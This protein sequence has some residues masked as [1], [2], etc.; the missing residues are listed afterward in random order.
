MG[1]SRHVHAGIIAVCLLA[2]S[3][4]PAA[5]QS[6]EVFVPAYFDPVQQNDSFG[7][8]WDDLMKAADMLKAAG[9]ITV[10][11]NPNSGPGG[12]KSQD[13]VN[14][15][16]R[17]RNKGGRVL[18][19]V[20]TCYGG[21]DDEDAVPECNQMMR[22]P[23]QVKADIETDIGKYIGWYHIDGFFLDEMTNDS[24]PAHLK[25]YKDIYNY[26]KSKN[27]RYRVIGNPGANTIK[28]YFTQFLTDALVIFEGPDDPKDADDPNNADE[29][30]KTF[31][32]YGWVNKYCS[33]RF[34][35]IVFKTPPDDP[36]PLLN[37]AASRN[38]GFVFM[39][40]ENDSYTSLPSYWNKEVMEI[41]K[42][43]ALNP[44]PLCTS[45][46]PLAW[47]GNAY[48][49]LGDGTTT[50]RLVPVPVS[51]LNGASA[52]A[53]GEEHS[54][55]L[56]ADGTVLAW[57]LNSYGEL[58]NG[59]TTVSLTPVPVTNLSGVIAIAAG[60]EHSLAL[61]AD[62]TVSAWGLNR[63]G[64]LG[65]GTAAVS[66]TPVPV[67][68]LVGVIAIAAGQEHS[69]ALKADG[70]VLAWGLNFYGELGNG[71][72]T[73]GFT[74]APVSN[75]T[76]V[77]AIAAGGEHS[78]ALKADGTVLAWG[79]NAYG[80]LGNGT[81]TVSLTPVPVSNLGGVIAIAA[82]HEH[83]L[84]LKADGTVRA[85]GLNAYGELGDATTIVS[86]TATPVSNL[87]EV[88]AIAAGGE[89]SLALAAF[90]TPAGNNVVVGPVDATT[91]TRPATLIFS[92]VNQAGVTTLTSSSMGPKVPSGFQLG[93]PSVYYQ[94]TTTA[95]F[96]PPVKVCISYSGITFPNNTPRLFHYENGMG[97]DVTT[98]VDSVNQMICGTV[99]SLSPF[100]LFVS[101]DTTP[102][103]TTAAA[104]PASGADG[105]NNSN[106]TVTLTSTDNEPGATGVKEIH[107]SLTGAQAGNTVVSGSTAS[108]TIS[109]EGSAVIT[110]FA[111]DNAGNKETPGTLTMRIDKTPPA[112]VCGVSPAVLWPPDHALVP[113]T[114]LV[115]VTDTL[116]G[117]AGFTLLSVTSNERDEGLGDGDRSHDIQG[118]V[119]GTPSTRSRLRAER[120]GP[121]SGRLYTLVYQ[122]VD[123]AGN[124]AT[125][126]AAV[127]VPH[128]RS[129]PP[130]SR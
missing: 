58:G 6:L 95:V 76:G 118:F 4:L 91:G 63:S 37:L 112:V 52:I 38:A 119:I 60:G 16:D 5:A 99:N 116:S 17:F 80:E 45:L 57:G 130:A 94:L 128:D 108:V 50:V 43:A 3:G 78:L 46:P 11:I 10:I 21:A 34:A 87:S 113:V 97:S 129:A 62:G 111:L 59:T 30:Y 35:H 40:D 74:P 114:A 49:D 7:A 56:K 92:S 22:T 61:N 65:N 39:T 25:Y 29:A 127:K 85:W 31:T 109:T 73:V 121:G 19:Y 51:N 107:L 117:S 36:Q 110:Y 66:L 54:L 18:G 24:D 82:G 48:G 102:P 101:G 1:K 120:S 70:T 126:N 15:V 41:A 13:Y 103:V 20:N 9:H 26:I 55:A 89:H 77:I 72:T 90:N 115:T 64:E 84:A 93:D 125:C 23:D 53:A 106:V 68:N 32:P 88:V 75:L 33:E 27:A 42:T 104:T 67:S 47:G 71:T 81:T 124:T 100:A 14:A 105:W 79:L 123:R 122:A 98:S 83:S 12:S 8:G 44:S 86:L 28:E 96:T 69:L 2:L